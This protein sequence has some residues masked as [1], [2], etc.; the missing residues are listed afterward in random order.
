LDAAVQNEPGDFVTPETV[1]LFASIGIKKGQPFQPDAR[2]KRILTDA[3]AIGNGAARALL[4]APRDPRWKLYPD[5]M[6]QVGFVGGSYLFADGA[7]RLLDARTRFFYYAT[8]ITPAMANAKPGTGSAYTPVFLDSQG[9][10]FDGGKTY[11][12]MLPGPVPA[13]Q[14]W[15]FTAYDNQ[16]RSLLETDQNTAGID[17]HANGLKA[18]P[19]GSYTIWFAPGAPKGEENNWVQTWPGKGFNVLLRL[20]APLEPWFDKSWKPGDFERVE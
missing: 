8:G 19:D 4:W 13:K 14:F 1:G 17:S 12:V 18:N 11:K 16:T 2:M 10:Q 15:S 5:R 20:Y 7:E 3:V 9:R 6:W